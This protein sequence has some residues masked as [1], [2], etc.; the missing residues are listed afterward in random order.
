M[1]CPYMGELDSVN[2][3]FS[4]FAFNQANRICVFMLPGPLCK[5]QFPKPDDL[6]DLIDI[7]MSV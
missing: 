1:L 7:L 2:Q 6:L 4:G 3:L 5:V